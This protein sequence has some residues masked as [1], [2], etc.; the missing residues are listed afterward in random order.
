MKQTEI[1]IALSLYTVGKTNFYS[2]SQ[3]HDLLLVTILVKLQK[4]VI[5]IM[6]APG[7]SSI[8]F[9]GLFFTI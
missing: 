6:V 1:N 3:M 4:A 7:F 5:H 9:H 8:R 2:S